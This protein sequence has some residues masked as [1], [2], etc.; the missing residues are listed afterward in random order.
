MEIDTSMQY[1]ACTQER[2]I[3]IALRWDRKTHHL[4]LRSR[5]QLMTHIPHISVSASLTLE[6]IHD[7]SLIILWYD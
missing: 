7:A 1:N 6:M 2:D 3:K 5:N 4:I